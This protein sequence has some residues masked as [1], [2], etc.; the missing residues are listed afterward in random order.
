MKPKNSTDSMFNL[1]KMYTSLKQ[2]NFFLS[3][4]ST[5]DAVLLSAKKVSGLW[6][7]YIKHLFDKR[8][9]FLSFTNTEL[10]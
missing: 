8:T 3:P 6:I 7:N 9:R 10:I 5:I 1:E 4:S 2:W